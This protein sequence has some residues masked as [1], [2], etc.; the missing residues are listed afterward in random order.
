MGTSWA[1]NYDK[2]HHF[3]KTKEKYEEITMKLSRM[4][5]FLKKRRSRRGSEDGYQLEEGGRGSITSLVNNEVGKYR[6]N[7]PCKQL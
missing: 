1:W 7:V 3:L 6:V 5:K 4:S 2:K